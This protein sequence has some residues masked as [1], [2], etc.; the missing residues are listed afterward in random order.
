MELRKLNKDLLIELIVKLNDFEKLTSEEL[1]E[2]QRKI[3]MIL[4][5]RKEKD[6]FLQRTKDASEDPELQKTFSVLRS[7]ATEATKDKKTR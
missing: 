6:K 2:K 5:S 1:R 4:I 7:E 3:E